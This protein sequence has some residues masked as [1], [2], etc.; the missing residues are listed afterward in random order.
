MLP[1]VFILMTVSLAGI[2]FIQYMW[3][4]NAYEVKESQFDQAVNGALSDV[5]YRLSR[6]EDVQF[7]S[8]QIWVNDDDSSD[9]N[10]TETVVW[11]DK[12]NEYSHSYVFV[13]DGKKHVKKISVSAGNNGNVFSVDALSD[14]NFRIKTYLKLDSIRDEL[15]ENQLVILTEFTDS[16]DVIV[17]KKMHEI[18]LKKHSLN[19]VID[20]MS[21]EI[22]SYGEPLNLSFTPEQIE[23]RVSEALSIKGI[24]LP[25]E[26]GV[27]L[28]DKDSITELRST[29]FSA[30]DNNSYKVN[31]FPDKIFKRPEFLMVSFPGRKSHI[32]QSMGL[33]LSGSFLFTLIIILTFFIAIRVIIRQKKLSEIKSD[34]INNMTHE[35]KTPI[36]TISLA[37]DSINNQLV[38]SNPE[39]IRY[40]TNIIGEENQR[41]NSRVENVL[42]M[43]LIDKNDFNLVLEE[44]NM[45]QLIDKAIS[46]IDLQLKKRGG[47]ISSDYKAKNPVFKGDSVHLTNIVMNLLDNA[48]KYSPEP[49]NL[50]IATVDNDTQFSFTVEDKGIGMT[51]EEQQ[52]IFD[53]FF[54]VSKG[55][56][57]NVKG[58]G[59]GLSYVK[60]IVLAMHGDISVKSQ[61]GEG[62]AFKIT[63]PKGNQS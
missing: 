34:F 35:F 42:Q 57:H 54:R 30:N 22:E 26:F 6:D 56:I 5:I 61:P 25:F 47:T 19:K 23:G 58:F 8:S 44:I 4:K 3:F 7:V 63:F 21:V 51:K 24:E 40:F 60:A 38:I 10:E 52:K 50:K 55:D 39:R 53:K 13:D 2:I 11:E 14:K 16:M 49:P 18:A 37:V 31:M 15:D 27:Y 9:V 59:L 32:L 12:E 45:H 29:N 1:V 48:I 62:T 41:M 20:D 36:A 28:P 46:N 17:Q 43:S 33:L